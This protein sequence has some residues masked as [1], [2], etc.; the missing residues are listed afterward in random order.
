MDRD[1]LPHCPQ[2]LV[3]RKQYE[4]L[5]SEFPFQTPCNL[6]NTTTDS[7]LVSFPTLNYNHIS[8]EKEQDTCFHFTGIPTDY[9]IQELV[10]YD[11][12][13]FIEHFPSLSRYS[14]QAM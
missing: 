8:Q 3:G 12:N 1:S 9:S 11:R 10:S 6:R 4:L 2:E 7:F 13:L 5:D 14:I